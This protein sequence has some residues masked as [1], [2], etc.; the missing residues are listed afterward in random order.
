MSEQTQQL[1]KRELTVSQILREYGKKFT[2]ITERYSDGRNGR[3]AMGVI[4]SYF[5]WNGRD[6]N[7]ASSKLLGTLIALRQ[8]GIDKNFLIEMNDSGMTFNE[9]AD[10]LDRSDKLTILK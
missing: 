7:H 10:I 2:Q 5:G 1:L 6:E 8:A 3:C 4:M 9:I